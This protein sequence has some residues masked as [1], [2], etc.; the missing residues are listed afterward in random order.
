LTGGVRE[1]S[2]SSCPFGGQTVNAPQACRS[3]AED[4]STATSTSSA[5]E[6]VTEK[7]Q[8][9]SVASTKAN[10]C[11]QFDGVATYHP[12]GLGRDQIGNM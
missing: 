6:G 4:A 11:F 12:N 9:T 2:V 7:T 1:G 8:E 3:V 5:R 10:A